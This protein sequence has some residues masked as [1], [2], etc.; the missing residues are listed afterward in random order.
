M[1]HIPSSN[2]TLTST[3]VAFD[4]YFMSMG[5]AHNKV[6][7]HDSMAV[8]G[9]WQGYIDD[10]KQLSYTGPPDGLE[11]P[12]FA[13]CKIPMDEW[14]ILMTHEDKV[15]FIDNF[16]PPPSAKDK[17]ESNDKE[18]RK[19]SPVDDDPL[20][21]PDHWDLPVLLGFKKYTPWAS[22]RWAKAEEVE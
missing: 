4:K 10:S 21:D 7:F 3:D 2:K 17:E 14:D 22:P 9:K 19:L 13:D 16:D 12:S 20:M 5:L 8:R 1:V 18:E 6:L 15:T 11:Y